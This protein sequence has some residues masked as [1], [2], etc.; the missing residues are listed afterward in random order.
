MN[1]FSAECGGRD[2]S[3]VDI[4]PPPST[5]LLGSW[6]QSFLG[7]NSKILSHD[8][9]CFVGESKTDILVANASARLDGYAA[10]LLLR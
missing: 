7:K 10:D 9:L 5:K 4:N 3:G 6:N 1:T 2:Q 8:K